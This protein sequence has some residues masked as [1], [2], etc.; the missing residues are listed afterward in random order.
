MMFWCL[1][2]RLHR[3]N[4]WPIFTVRYQLV[5]LILFAIIASTSQIETSHA[6]ERPTGNVADD[7]TQCPSF[8]DNSACPCYKFEDGELIF[9]CR[10]VL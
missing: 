7:S 2:V 5:Q 6:R 10:N 9:R 4:E 8:T 1:D 3:P